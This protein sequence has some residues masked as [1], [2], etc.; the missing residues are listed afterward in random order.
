[1]TLMVPHVVHLQDV[2]KLHTFVLGHLGALLLACFGFDLRFALVAFDLVSDSIWCEGV[3]VGV[4]ARGGS[5]WAGKDYLRGALGWERRANLRTTN[6]ARSHTHTQAQA[7]QPPHRDTPTPIPTAFQQLRAQRGGLAL[8]RRMTAAVGVA[9][10]AAAVT[11]SC[12]LLPLPPVCVSPPSAHFGCRSLFLFPPPTA[13]GES[14]R[15]DMSDLMDVVYT[16]VEDLQMAATSAPEASDTAVM[17]QAQ[18]S[19]DGDTVFVN[20]N[21]LVHASAATALATEALNPRH[22]F[23]ERRG[24]YPR[25]GPGRKKG[26]GLDVRESLHQVLLVLLS[27]SASLKLS[28]LF[29]PSELI[30]VNLE[31]LRNLRH[32]ISTFTYKALR[33]RAR[34]LSRSGAVGALVNT[35]RVGHGITKG[36]TWPWLW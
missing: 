22:V 36:A 1:V 19:R 15:M 13:A 5:T 4:G 24:G 7:T 25:R 16:T 34:G 30:N 14:V 26:S 10:S 35:V 11:L 21:D 18:R 8:L 32:K 2:V 28:E 27:T 6:K 33:T 23:F 29:D 20:A 17:A 31:E 3:G 9:S 12:G